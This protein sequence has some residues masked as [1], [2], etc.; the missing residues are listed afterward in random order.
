[1]INVPKEIRIRLAFLCLVMSVCIPLFCY[2]K[3]QLDYDRLH[4]KSDRIYKLVTDWSTPGEQVS[5][6]ISSYNAAARIDSGL[7]TLIEKSARIIHSS[8]RLKSSNSHSFSVDGVFADASVFEI[9]DFDLV[10]GNAQ[11]ALQN[12]FTAVLT[13]KTA[14]ALFGEQNPV[15]KLFYLEDSKSPVTVTGLV[16]E[17]PGNSQIQAGLFFSLPTLVKL[18]YRDLGG[19]MDEMGVVTYLLFKGNTDGQT[20]SEAVNKLFSG[21]ETFITLLT[22]KSVRIEPL[23]NGLFNPLFGPFQVF[24]LCATVVI[25]LLVLLE[26]LNSLVKMILLQISL[27]DDYQTITNRIRNRRLIRRVCLLVL[28]SGT[29]AIVFALIVAA[30]AA[31][32]LDNPFSQ[33][34]PAFAAIATGTVI[35][36]IVS[37]ILI[38][39]W[40]VLRVPSEPMRTYLIHK[41]S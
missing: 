15:G 26:S 7:T 37:S 14:A 32:F 23:R 13:S 5:S 30:A 17:I 27:G 20:A 3:Y 10:S 25:M 16:Q 9:F 21:Q 34:I 2:F 33:H 24:A 38:S 18:H 35:L 4:T 41:K 29:I 8:F 28:A 11:T 39:Y 40:I 31:F 1:M 6:S 36:S 12:P 19:K 22:T